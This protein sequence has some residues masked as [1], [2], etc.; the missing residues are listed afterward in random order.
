LGPGIPRTLEG[1]GPWK[2]APG[3]YELT[4]VRD[5]IPAKPKRFEV[6]AGQSLELALDWPALPTSPVPSARPPQ[7]RIPSHASQSTFVSGDPPAPPP[8]HYYQPPRP[9]YRPAARPVYR[10]PLEPL[11]TPIPPGRYDPPPPPAP[12]YPSGPEPLFTPLP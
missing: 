4:A 8:Y 9:A 7:A 12:S 1:K 3:R 2:L 6:K 5:K 10:A 11:F